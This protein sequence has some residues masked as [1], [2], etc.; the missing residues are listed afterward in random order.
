MRAVLLFIVLSVFV[1][2]CN[3]S[4]ENQYEESIKA[5]RKEI[6]KIF[7]IKESSPLED[8]DRTY[9]VG[10]NYFPIDQSYAVWASYRALPPQ[11]STMNTTGERTADYLKAATLDFELLGKRIQLLAYRSTNP[12][13]ECLF[14][15]FGDLTNGESSYD[16]GRYIDLEEPDSNMLLLDFNKSYNPYCAYSDKWSCVIPPPEN[17]LDLKIEAGE[18]KFH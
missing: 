3:K 11:L 18:M 14:L 12:E 15:P 13:D 17:R 7:L 5:H 4:A 6:T 2:A 16:A 10:L 1:F 9:F 8:E